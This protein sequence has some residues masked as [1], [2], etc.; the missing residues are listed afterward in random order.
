MTSSA[1]RLFYR[2]ITD[3]EYLLADPTTGEIV[4]SFPLPMMA[5]QISGRYVASYSIRGV[6]V[7]YPT[8]QWRSQHEKYAEEF[9]RREKE[10]PELFED[11]MPSAAESTLW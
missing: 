9:E 1:D 6:F 3:D 11:Q 5:L 4:F 8:K 7:A 10:T 2:T